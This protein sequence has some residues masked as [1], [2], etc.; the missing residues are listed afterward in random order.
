M[1]KAGLAWVHR[2]PVVHLDALLWQ[3]VLAL[4]GQVWVVPRSGIN[5]CLMP[6]YHGFM[7]QSAQHSQ[8]RSPGSGE[9]AVGRRQRAGFAPSGSRVV[10][11]LPGR[12]A[13]RIVLPGLPYLA[14]GTFGRRCQT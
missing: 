6:V 4:A 1:H 8:P 12:G 11:D 2:V 13:A 10:A 14:Q 7:P 5:E 9:P 3:A